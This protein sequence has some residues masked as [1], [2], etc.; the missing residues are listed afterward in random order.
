M[1]EYH[2]LQ[3]IIRDKKRVGGDI[4]TIVQLTV[5]ECLKAVNKLDGKIASTVLADVKYIIN[6]HFTKNSL[7]TST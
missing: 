7:G 1:I 4:E 3:Q 2:L 5:N 6:A